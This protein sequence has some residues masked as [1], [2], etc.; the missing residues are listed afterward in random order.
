MNVAATTYIWTKVELSEDR[1]EITHTKRTQTRHGDTERN[2]DEDSEV[3]DAVAMRVDCFFHD[4]NGG[5]LCEPSHSGLFSA[6][7][8]PTSRILWNGPWRRSTI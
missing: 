6:L 5:S 8:L 4:D 7:Q 1:K 2:E 3:D